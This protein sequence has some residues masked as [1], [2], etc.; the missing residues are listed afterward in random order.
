MTENVDHKAVD[1]FGAE[2]AKYD[3]SA[4]SQKELSVAFAEYFSL[5]DWS[6]IATTDCVAMDVGC[7]S[8]RWAEF[9]APRV[10]TLVLVDPSALALEV[11][12]QKLSAFDNCSFFQTTTQ[13]LPGDDGS[14]DLI[15]SLGVLHH[16]PDTYAG[17]EDCIKKLKP[18]APLLLYLYYRFDNRPVWFAKV[19]RLSDVIRKGISRLPFVLKHPLSVIIAT[20]VYWPLARLSLAAE[21]L[22]GR[23][24]SSWPLSHY[25]KSPFYSMRTDSLDRFG[26]RLEHRFTR[27]EINNMLTRAGLTNVKFR[28]SEPFWCVIGFKPT[29][30]S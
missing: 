19:W 20:F 21:K 1:S 17:I 8:G 29:S 7:G 10:G 25:R 23:N 28:E 9:V 27:A 12:R 18:G 24:V 30:C 14:Y 11:A 22:L 15:Y 16:I 6:S 13:N 5:L 4:L 26:T 2:W 3:Q